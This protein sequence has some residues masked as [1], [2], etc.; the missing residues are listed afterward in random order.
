LERLIIE[1]EGER[2]FKDAKGGFQFEKLAKLTS[3]QLTQGPCSGSDFHR[4]RIR[5]TG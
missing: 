5:L 1:P 3:R 2:E 4:S